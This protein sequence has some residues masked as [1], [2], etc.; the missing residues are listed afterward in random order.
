MKIRNISYSSIGVVLP[1]LIFLLFTPIIIKNF[2]VERFGYISLFWVLLSVSSILD[3]GVSRALTH[4]VAKNQGN[5][6]AFDS[7]YSVL[8]ILSV[9]SVIVGVLFYLVFITI[10]P[11]LSNIPKILVEELYQSSLYLSLC[12]PFVILYSALRGVFEGVASFNITA[13]SKLLMGIVMVVPLAFASDKSS[14]LMY[15]AEVCLF[16]RVIG[17]SMLFYNYTLKYCPQKYRVTLKGFEIFKF[18]AKVSVSTLS[19][20]ML[21]YSDRFFASFFL[22]PSA[23]GIYSLCTELVMRFLFIP[24]AISS[25]LFQSL[26]QSTSSTEVRTL[27]LRSVKYITLTILPVVLILTLFGNDLLLLWSNVKIPEELNYVI[28]VLSVGLLVNSYGHLS[29]AYLQSG[30]F[31]DFT[32]KI[33]IFELIVFVPMMF[34]MSQKYGID[35]L[36]FTW[37]TRITFDFMAMTVRGMK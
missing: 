37:L 35:G 34:I 7:V 22:S 17:F 18:G 14:T 23:F 36:L 3:L 1:A 11:T 5:R 16:T 2:G 32:A 26:S 10:T 15:A 27:M 19:S 8:I 12:I 20:S 9:F 29:Y 30:R 25:V 13:I 31:L 6:D 28:T 24:G 21:V 4:Y 33:H